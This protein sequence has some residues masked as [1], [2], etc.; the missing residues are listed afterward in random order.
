MYRETPMSAKQLA[1]GPD[2]MEWAPVELDDEQ[3]VV[4]DRLCRVDVYTTEPDLLAYLASS[5][6]DPETFFRSLVETNLVALDSTRLVLTT[7]QL[8]IVIL[9]DGRTVAGEN[10]TGRLERWVER[11]MERRGKA[12]GGGSDGGA[13]LGDP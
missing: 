12:G 11:F 7:V 13:E 5:G 4:L 1:E 3:N 9:P 6:R 8:A 10:N 2:H